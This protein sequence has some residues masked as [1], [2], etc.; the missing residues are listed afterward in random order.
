MVLITVVFTFRPFV[1]FSLK[2]KKSKKYPK[3]QT[4]YLYGQ[5]KFY[6]KIFRLQYPPTKDYFRSLKFIYL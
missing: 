2:K 3:M 4:F 6:W 5:R 1:I